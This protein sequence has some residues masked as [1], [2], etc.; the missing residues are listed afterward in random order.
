MLKSAVNSRQST[1]K[2]RGKIRRDTAK[3]RCAVDGIDYRKLDLRDALDLAILIEEEAGDIYLEFAEQMEN[4]HTA[5]AARFF[6]AMIQNE[7]KHGE[8]LTERRQALFGSEPRRVDRSLLFH[9]EAP[10]YEK[11]RA[12]M[13][14]REALGVALDCER[15]AQAFFRG[16]L[17]HVS[18]PEARR[19]FEEL[20]EEEVH[21]EK[22]V[23]AELDRLP[24][25]PD[26]S[27][28][29]YADEPV[30]Q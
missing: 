22:L 5:E 23:S 2:A 3:G 10:E 24:P 14:R 19:L 4:Q 21:H 20:A 1:G 8:E 18:D 17:E 6:R 7:K 25:D 26:V 29:D 16:A 11:A 12:F 15:K 9:V 30:A 27:A 28:E 13:S